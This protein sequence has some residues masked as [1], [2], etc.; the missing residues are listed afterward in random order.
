MIRA[1]QP[2]LSPHTLRALRR[3]MGWSQQDAATWAFV[4]LR[5][6]RRWE[7]AHT[8]P[9]GFMARA[10][11]SLPASVQLQINLYGDTP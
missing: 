6:W 4:D 11:Q 10:L 7:R 3:V 1:D 8:T 9:P 5:T 2:R